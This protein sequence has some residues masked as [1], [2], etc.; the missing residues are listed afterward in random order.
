MEPEIFQYRKNKQRLKECEEDYLS[1]GIGMSQ[2]IKLGSSFSQR[3]RY[4][5]PRYN[6]KQYLKTNC[7]DYSEDH[8]SFMSSAIHI[9]VVKTTFL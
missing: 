2:K 8:N 5:Q 9:Q 4:C 1:I 7:N 6:G 3:E